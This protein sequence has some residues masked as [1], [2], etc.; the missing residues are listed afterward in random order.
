MTRFS[1]PWILSNPNSFTEKIRTP[2]KLVGRVAEVEKIEAMDT[3]RSSVHSCCPCDATARS[4]K[5]DKSGSKTGKSCRPP[6]GDF[7]PTK[8]T[9]KEFISSGGGDRK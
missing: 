6:V 9:S 8:T 1:T 3:T 5:S 7:M 2:P 4:N